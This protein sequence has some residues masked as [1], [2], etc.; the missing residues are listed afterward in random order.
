MPV[1]IPSNGQ[2]NWAP[3]ADAALQYLDNQ[4]KAE[5]TRALA[6]EALLAT[7]VTSVNGRTGVVN[8][9]STDVNAQ[10]V[11]SDLSA[12]AALSTT[13]F[14]RSLLTQTDAPSVRTLLG[15]AS[16]ASVSLLVPGI[17]P[18]TY[19]QIEAL[20]GA[21]L[22]TGQQVYQTDIGTKR[23]NPGVYTYNGVAW[24]LP[25]NI[26]W[27]AL[28]PPTSLGSSSATF[29][30]YANVPGLPQVVTIVGNRITQI[31]FLMPFHC[32]TS[33][34]GAIA[35]IL[36]SGTQI[37]EAEF[38][39]DP[40]TSGQIDVTFM[41]TF[42]AGIH[43]FTPQI[44]HNVAGTVGLTSSVVRPGLLIIEDLGPNGVPV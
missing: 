34:N 44:A 25:W 22:W 39:P 37:Q 23:P 10:P 40:G 26:P 42:S 1:P 16:T 43:T 35:R 33:G 3:A 38:A 19:A 21:G 17:S 12:I 6:A 13:T 8:L 36:D 18:L 31:R 30:G 11:D 7:R 24:R 29:V 32:D 28:A 9:T 4:S 2:Q 15:A 14:G 27:G 20:A 41:G 5:T